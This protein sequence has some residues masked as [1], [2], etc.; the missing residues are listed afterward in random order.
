SPLN[1]QE[2]GYSNGAELH[3]SPIPRTS[4]DKSKSN[5][6]VEYYAY[7]DILDSC[8][9]LFGGDLTL[10]L[11]QIVPVNNEVEPKVV[12]LAEES[13]Q[14]ENKSLGECSD[15][16]NEESKSTTF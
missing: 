5:H 1:E 4:L 15:S 16:T 7:T 14:M 9:F 11:L 10:T 13:I 8:K 3:I 2:E 12:D 6:S